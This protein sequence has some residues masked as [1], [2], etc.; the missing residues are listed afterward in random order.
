MK[1]F[2]NMNSFKFLDKAFEGKKNRLLMLSKFA[3]K[4]LEIISD[5]T[6][7]HDIYEDL[8]KMH[9]SHWQLSNEM[10][11]EFDYVYAISKNGFLLKLN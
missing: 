6:T 4:R 10:N 9:K 7:F 5:F 3:E 11:D 2:F 1:C 8:M